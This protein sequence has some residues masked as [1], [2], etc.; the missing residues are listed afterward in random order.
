MK[1]ADLHV[2][3]SFSD[4]PSEW[5]LQKLGTAESYTA[6]EFIYKKC[7]E[8]GM[9]FVTVT[10]HN[11]IK[12][13]MILKKL[14]PENVIP[15]VESTVYF[16]ED[17]C[18]IHLLIYNPTENQFGEI[19]NK[20]ENIY[21]LRDYLLSENLAHSV[22][23]ATYSVNNILTLEHL[24]KL[25]LLF[26]VFEARNG[27]RDSHSNSVWT[28]VLSSLTEE[29]LQR[30]ENKY[31]IRP[32]SRNPWI[33]G[34]TG[35]SDDH[36][37]IF[38]GKTHTIF[39]ADS[40]QEVIDAL[41]DKQ[42][43]AGGRHNNYLSFVFAIYKIAYDFSKTK[44]SG[45][46]GSLFKSLSEFIFEKDKL[47]LKDKMKVNHIKNN[48]KKNENKVNLLL[49][50]LVEELGMEKNTPAEKRFEL[51]HSNV[52][53]IADTFL[54]GFFS[55]L[56]TDFKNG[57]ITA[58]IKNISA[59][60]PAGFLSVPFFT[61][62]HHFNTNRGLINS[63]KSKYCPNMLSKGKR[64]LWFTDTYKDLNG[65]SV[66][67]NNLMSHAR[68]MKRDISVV[69]C[70][71][72]SPLKLDS[73]YSFSVPY[74]EAC[75]LKIPSMLMS[76]K[77]IYEYNPDEIYISTPGP[78]GLLGLLAAKVLNIKATSIYHTDFSLQAAKITSDSA[79]ETLVDSS[80]KWFYSLSDSVQVPSRE[81]IKTLKNRGYD[82]SKMS[83][84]RRGLD[85]SLIKPVEDA[86]VKLKEQF[87]IPENGRVLLYTG[88]ISRDKNL[89]FLSDVYRSLLPEFHDLKLLIAGDGPY[90]DNLRANTA[91]LKGIYFL[92]RQPQENMPLIYSSADL[93]MFPSVTD[94]FGMSVLEAQ[95]CGI[96]AIVS[97]K[98]GPQ[99]IIIDKETGYVLP[100]C[101]DQ[102]VTAVRDFFKNSS[103]FPAVHE[104]MKFKARRNVLENYSWEKIIKLITG[105]AAEDQDETSAY[106]EQDVFTGVL[107]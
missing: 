44:S 7:M 97:D 79:I 93:F 76:L 72:E 36:A 73:I 35:G 59:L 48:A 14:H 16:P 15:G 43:S 67:L 104:I 61:S 47:S 94:T 22:A 98:G 39:Q 95:A 51:V 90:L 55:S 19:E 103:E 58:L 1:K 8:A 28:E 80:L 49:T 96:P 32:A 63:L 17:G 99:E 100:V 106:S 84:F 23:H 86:R 69:S 31:R 102:W 68:Q 101:K 40:P 66:T 56:Q 21:K 62:L 4:R 3:S 20:R 60:I 18:K 57:D 2:H 45:S 91:G 11:C 53:K 5:F 50:N 26:D 105:T 88:R 74:Y 107:C 34:M 89:D 10:D 65:V 13:S 81:Y 77:K 52:S 83:V 29:H 70:A 87:G 33:K 41:R 71:E 54:T 25:I 38:I 27:A 12:A 78:V 6:P 46:G 9:D 42:C 82:T 37:G 24:E 30:L 64:I 75:S 85:T 92:G